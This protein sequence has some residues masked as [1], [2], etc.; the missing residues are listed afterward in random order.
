MASDFAGKA[1][2]TSMKQH[3]NNKNKESQWLR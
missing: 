2:I 3:W 1:I